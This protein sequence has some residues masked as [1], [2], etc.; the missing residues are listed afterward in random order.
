MEMVI[1]RDI[2]AIGYERASIWI[3]TFGSALRVV[4]W[5]QVGEHKRD[6]FS[7]REFCT[8][9][10]LPVNLNVFFCSSFVSFNLISKFY[11]S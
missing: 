10:L 8:Y 11:Q 4:D 7:S 5:R 6:F 3:F 2:S 9:N 1:R